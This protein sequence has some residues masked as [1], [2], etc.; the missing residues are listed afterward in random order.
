M[1]TPSTLSTPSKCFWGD[2]VYIFSDLKVFLRGLSRRGCWK[3]TLLCWTSR[4]SCPNFWTHFFPNLFLPNYSIRLPQV[5]KVSNRAEYWKIL[6]VFFFI[7]VFPHAFEKKIK[8]GL[9]RFW[10]IKGKY[11]KSEKFQI[12]QNPGKFSKCFFLNKRLSTAPKAS[13]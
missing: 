4:Y 6:Q 2:G 3:F 9:T 8:R 11:C 7:D 12:G 5:R 10:W 1:G 13:F